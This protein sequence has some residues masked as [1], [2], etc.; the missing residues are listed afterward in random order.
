[1]K[2]FGELFGR[3]QSR[4]SR[5]SR[6]AVT[7]QSAAAKRR[8]K[9]SQTAAPERLEQRLLLATDVWNQFGGLGETQYGWT[10]FTQG[11]AGDDLYLRETT[12]TDAFGISNDWQYSNNADFSD[13][14]FTVSNASYRDV[15]ITDAVPNGVSGNFPSRFISLPG[16]ADVDLP[17]TLTP[18]TYEFG[19]TPDYDVISG[20]VVP[21]T[22]SGTLTA[23]S[24]S[25][26]FPLASFG[27]R[28]QYLLD[29]FDGTRGDGVPVLFRDGNDFWVTTATFP[30]GDQTW[31]I[32][33]GVL[34]YRDGTFR[35]TVRNQD[36]DFVATSSDVNFFYAS[37]VRSSLASNVTLSPGLDSN[38]GFY[39]NPTGPDSTISIE[40]SIVS[41]HTVSLQA[42]NVEIDAP[43]STQTGNFASFLVAAE[44][45]TFAAPVE[46]NV[47]SFFIADDTRTDA[48]TRG[49]LLLSSSGP[50]TGLG[51]G[52][53]FNVVVEAV[54]SD[55]RVESV[56]AGA[57]QTYR[58][59]T[60]T[61]TVGGSLS[62][63]D[64]F[65]QPTGELRGN[66]IDV[67]LTNETPVDPA[68]SLSHLVSLD[69][70][71]NSL[72]IFAANTSTDGT[73]N[74]AVTTEVAATV[75][76]SADVV[77][78][79][80]TG[81]GVGDIVVESGAGVFS[82]IPAG[83][84]VTAIDTTTNTLTLSGNVF[85]SA[86]T[87]L[88]FLKTVVG[89]VAS[90]TILAVGDVTGIQL[91]DVVAE[92]VTGGGDA[93][94]IPANT[95]VVGIDAGA[96]ELTLSQPVSVSD[97]TTL[98]FYRF[99]QG[100]KPFNYD[101]QVREA[102]A[103]NVDATLTS[104]GPVSVAAAGALNVNASVNSQQNVSLFSGATL[105]GNAWLS[106]VE[107]GLTLEASD[108]N[109][110]GRL[111]VLAAP[112]DNSLTDISVTAT[113]G[114]ILLDGGATAVNQIR[115]EQRG[116]GDVIASNRLV[117][118]N[119]IIY[120]AGNVDAETDVRYADIETSG[121][122]TITESND[123]ELSISTTGFTRLTALGTDPVGEDRAAL[124]AQLRRTTDVVVS[125]PAGSIDVTAL[126]AEDVTIGDATA[127]LSG[128]ASSMQAAGN[129]SIRA[130][131]GGIVALDAPLAG[132]SR[133]QARAVSSATGTGNL[134]GTYAQ[135]T[136]GQTPATLTGIGN[137]SLNDVLNFQVIFPGFRPVSD[138]SPNP[139]R[140]R[141]IVLLRG[142]E[143][144]YENGLY[145]I[146]SLGSATTPWVLT[147]TAFT[148]VTSEFE[149][150]TRVSVTDG[151]FAGTSF[152]VDGYDNALNATPLSVTAGLSRS[153]NEYAVRVATD[154]VLNGS[155]DGSGVISGS[156]PALLVNGISINDGD[157]VLVR[158]GATNSN[159][160]QVPS[161][162]ANGVYVKS[163][164]GAGN[165]ALT[166]YT[167]PV[168]ANVV[169]EAKVIVQEGFYRTVVT[170]ESFTVRYDGLGLVDVSINEA[171]FT[172][173][174]GSYDPRDAT[175]FVVSTASG[176]NRDAGS[177][178]KMLSLIQGNEAKHLGE[179]VVTQEV[180]FGN[181]LG[182]VTGPTGTIQ[183][184]QE[185][186]QIE[187]PFTISVSN[188]YALSLAAAQTIIVDGSR[189]TTSRENTFAG[190]TTEINGLEYTAGASTVLTPTPEE[191]V[192]SRLSGLQLAG[193]ETG[194]AVVVD[195]A[196]NILI[197]NVTVGRN[198][199]G[200]SQ[201]G[202]YGIVVTGDAG[203]DGPVSLVNNTIA[204]SSVF[205]PATEPLIGSGVLVA[206]QAQYVQV[207]GGT[208]GGAIGANTTGIT[209]ESSNDNTTQANSIGVNPLPAT[210][211]TTTANRATITIPAETWNVIGNDL[212]IGQTLTG[213]GIASGSRI[214]AIDHDARQIVL[215]ERMTTSVTDSRISFGTPGRTNVVDNFYGVQLRSGSTRMA[216]TTVADNVLDGIVIGT[217]VPDA[218]WAQ[219]GAGI[220]L[221]SAGQPDP[222][223]RTTASNA[224][225]GNGR[226]GIRF[227]SG[228][229]TQTFSPST[230]FPF[231][232]VPT[233]IVIEGNFVGTNTS[234][235]SGLNN[236]R[237]SYYWDA[238][239]SA[240]I[241]PDGSAGT[242][243]KFDSLI[244]SLDP[245]GPN[246]AVDNGNGNINVDLAAGSG[247]GGGGGGDTGGG[248]SIP[249]PPRR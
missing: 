51:G 201:G 244:T 202:L 67:L 14:D 85:V 206:G 89:D 47:V 232:P 110:G 26:G 149:V 161:T 27:V 221:D 93:S 194:G 79:D 58:Y 209:V 71:I 188:R 125:A 214:L 233:Q 197:E 49:E 45:A 147:R 224:I 227:G 134:P 189:I 70:D 169:E 170:G 113:N 191:A 207:V 129:V 116:S 138:A 62:T 83:T 30:V 60:V 68:D 243:E 216:N 100:Y 123:A 33:D 220:A 230:I 226:Y 238:T 112:F 228:V 23:S 242:G 163:T 215:S 231:D 193:F 241:P 102:N 28:A 152:R 205:G 80:T 2:N 133:L 21:G 187:K 211:L 177:L 184:Q 39:A 151:D 117:S 5:S 219:I 87:Q 210:Q 75:A 19:V 164:N 237:A 108:V 97:G 76:F 229:T 91:G 15:L 65:G 46:S 115:L 78:T 195:G 212:Y 140:V 90:D 126:T 29:H 34:D 43:I 40:S 167:D 156:V 136:P 139:L 53:A 190:R 155:F 107:G 204:S 96:N 101:I 114:S 61:S 132:D 240:T 121:D 32:S 92:L 37:P 66:Q 183:L 182:Y 148:E 4:K 38:S 146:T 111:Q 64:S 12:S 86:G 171:A 141:D 245:D 69:T 57:T 127:L 82:G 52:N 16:A 77:V 3:L 8:R 166:R 168:T 249:T 35:Y 213:S 239:D 196:S 54:D 131:Q 135:N 203:T 218:I 84:T 198:S 145:Q 157:L 159:D 105:T 162:N 18:A 95:Y 158:Y 143:F 56:L 6:T 236:G 99:R 11:D 106:S 142:Q 222:K 174:I 94:G 180:R 44:N 25:T 173:A 50:V 235:A 1:M 24:L 124:R 128:L 199:A 36:G 98:E 185:L 48:V 104:G 247:G 178:G 41:G 72:R 130:S 223:I 208:I 122:V 217:S 17:S 186:P 248:G 119:L 144:G 120:A 22:F 246:P 153:A 137:G 179:E 81:I 175:T 200:E 181:V 172:S 103:L 165:W 10:V 59:S 160:G 176:T 118:E 150:G 88:S 63:L 154:T 42:T 74:A 31:S 73:V 109:L 20:E 7:G 192:Q 55:V 9:A 225:Y 234:G 13:S